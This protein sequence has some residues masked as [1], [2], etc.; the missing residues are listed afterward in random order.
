[1][2][3]GKITVVL[4]A[5]SLMGCGTLFGSLEATDDYVV[6]KAN[7]AGEVV[8]CNQQGYI[9]TYRTHQ[10]VYTTN[11]LL[12][13][14]THDEK[15]YEKAFRARVNYM[16]GYSLD[17]LEGECERLDRSLPKNLYSLQQE[18]HQV[19]SRLS[20]IRAQSFNNMLGAVADTAP[21]EGL[22]GL[23]SFTGFTT[24]PSNQVNYGQ[25]ETSSNDY[26]VNTSSGLVHCNVS[27]S[28][29]VNCY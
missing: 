19:A 14:G 22:T 25:T 7:R 29:Y 17:F 11:Q 1:M 13:L 27:D 3:K 4:L 18:Y 16:L 2:F 10:F 20:N 26:L 12:G 15:L 21:A 8:A 6:H 23:H 28:G 9:G 24:P 5:V